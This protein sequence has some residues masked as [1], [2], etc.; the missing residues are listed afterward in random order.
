MRYLAH[1]SRIVF[2]QGDMLPVRT[3]L[4]NGSFLIALSM[5]ID[6]D[7]FARPAYGLLA[8]MAPQWIWAAAFL[9]H[10]IGEYSHLSRIG[11]PSWMVLAVNIYGFVLW[12]MWTL[13]LAIEVGTFAPTQAMAWSMVAAS[14]W[15]LFC[16]ER[17]G[18][19]EPG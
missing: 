9:L 1:L 17:R 6:R 4:A 7:A 8:A 13:S 15:A 2:V 3:L 19:P 12:F 10:S 16:T 14:G 18:Q 11:R 5:A